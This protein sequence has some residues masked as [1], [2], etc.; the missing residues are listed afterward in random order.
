[1]YFVIMMILVLDDKAGYL[2]RPE[3]SVKSWFVIY[4]VIL[5]QYSEK[6]IYVLSV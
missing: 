6:C 4:A 1:M 2:A 5:K 3:I